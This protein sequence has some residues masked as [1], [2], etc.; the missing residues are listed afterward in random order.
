MV[1]PYPPADSPVL[2]LTG[3]TQRELHLLLVGLNGIAP[4]RISALADVPNY[5]ANCV[6][7]EAESAHEDFRAFGANLGFPAHDSAEVPYEYSDL[8]E[9]L[10]ALSI[11]E[12]SFLLGF[13]VGFWE[14]RSIDS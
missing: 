11:T 13:A 5:L 4:P 9:K 6:H 2:E 10:R 8:A 1:T 7:S 14:G 3:L 12:A